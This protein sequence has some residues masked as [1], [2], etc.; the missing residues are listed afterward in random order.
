MTRK[1]IEGAALESWDA[2][3][4]ALAE[5]GA[6]DRELAGLEAGQNEKIDQVKE[7][8]KRL[9]QPLLDRKTMAERAIKE[10]C[11]VNRAEF[12]KVKTKE[13]TFGSVGFRLST[14]IMVKSVA[15]TLQTLKDLMLP[16]CIRIKEELDK[17]AMKA[18]PDETLAEVGAAR[19]TENVFG[20]EVKQEEIKDAA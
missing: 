5:I 10:Y 20:Y 11:Q 13:M 2:V 8:T 18:L 3:D 17:E 16:G 19:K 4:M 12:A 1:R 15:N 7:Q 6:I 14:K 9:A